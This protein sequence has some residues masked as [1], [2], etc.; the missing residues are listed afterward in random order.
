MWEPYYSTHPVPQL[1][2]G[3]VQA[4]QSRVL[5][6]VELWKSMMELCL[7][8]WPSLSK[9]DNVKVRDHLMHKLHLGGFVYP[10]PGVDY[11]CLK[12]YPWDNIDYY[13]KDRPVVGPKA[14]EAAAWRAK[15]KEWT[16]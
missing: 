6:K 7:I 12:Y 2:D 15:I 4:A 5:A 10:W 11:I 9:A 8:V 14:R 13:D 1:N 16:K 3:V